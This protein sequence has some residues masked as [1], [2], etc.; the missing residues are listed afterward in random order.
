VRTLPPTLVIDLGSTSAAAMVVTDQSAWL[1]PDPERGESRWPAAIHWDGERIATGAAAELMAAIRTQA[2]RSHGPINRALLTIPASMSVT[3]SRRGH[4]LE[5]AVAAGFAATELLV[6]PA[7]AVWAPGSP[8]RIGDV[9]L[10]YDLGATF[11]A[12]VIR[13]GDDLPEIAG[14]TSIVDWPPDDSTA[15][16]WSTTAVELT[17]ASCR[18]LL[19]RSALGRHEVDW[20]LPV[21]GGARTPGLEA[22]LDRGLGIAVAMVDEPELAVVRGAAQWLPRSGPRMV[23]ARPSPDRMV[24][25]VFTFP[26]GS[27]QLLRWLVEPTQPYDAGAPVARVRL[28]SGAVWDLTARTR[29]T[30]DEVLVP[31]GHPVSTGDWLALVRPR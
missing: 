25:L 7:G 9:V 18:D 28:S 27:A 21:G 22:A 8:V 11:D 1:V 26:G 17:M 23:L 24:P 14:H 30:L 6:A 19:A 4:L 16:N 20:V 5:A 12:A 29:G 3:D 10:V 13:V 31:G 2:L 15:G